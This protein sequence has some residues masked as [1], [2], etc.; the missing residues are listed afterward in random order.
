[1]SNA[2]AYHVP[3]AALVGI[4]SEI[5]FE[6]FFHTDFCTR[7]FHLRDVSSRSRQAIQWGSI[8]VSKQL[9]F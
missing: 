6:K 5:E 3:E 1:M 8:V 2:S 9:Y 4:S 7:L